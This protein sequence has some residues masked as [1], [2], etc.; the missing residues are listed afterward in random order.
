MWVKDFFQALLG[1]FG[2]GGK[3]ADNKSKRLDMKIV[4][5][6]EKGNIRA[7]INTKKELK[8]RKEL[9]EVFADYYIFEDE[10][11]V[12]IEVD[13]K[14]EVIMEVTN[15]DSLSNFANELKAI[16]SKPKKERK[17]FIKR[18]KANAQKRRKKRQSKRNV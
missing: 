10:T 4:E 3:I 15:I 9:I 11:G 18:M 16:E 2:F 14:G 8:E 17:R 1:F 5:H 13:K 7:V 12:S 6:S